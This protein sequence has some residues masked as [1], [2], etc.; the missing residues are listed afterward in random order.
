MTDTLQRVDSSVDARRMAQILDQ[1]GALIVTDALT[2]RQLRQINGEV[3]D[4]MQATAP[5]LR[6]PSTDYYVGFYDLLPDT[7]DTFI[8]TLDTSLDG[9]SFN[10]GNSTSPGDFNLYTGA[11]WMIR[12]SGGAVDSA[13]ISLQWDPACNE[14]DTPGQDYGVYGGSLGDFLTTTPLTCSTDRA[15]SYLTSGGTGDRYFVVVPQ[16][17]AAEGS[18][19]LNGSGAQRLPSAQACNPQDAASCP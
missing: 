13:S 3:D 8:A 11:T 7:P 15:T 18:Y 5:G 17:S 10:T 9:D 4:L 2:P 16:T 1:D 14:A 19:G 6:H 12:A